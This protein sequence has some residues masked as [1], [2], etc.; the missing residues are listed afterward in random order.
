MVFRLK[1]F[2]CLLSLGKCLSTRAR[3]LCPMLVLVFLLKRGLYKSM[4][5]CRFFCLLAWIE[6]LDVKTDEGE[7]LFVFDRLKPVDYGC[8]FSID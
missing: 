7:E 4:L 8:C 3:N 2:L 6:L 1:I 5:F